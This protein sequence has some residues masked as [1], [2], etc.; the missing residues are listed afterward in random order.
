M[1]L[2]DKLRSGASGTSHRCR[3]AE[4]R[5]RR[6]GGVEGI[7]EE[8]AKEFAAKGYDGARVDEIAQAAGVNKATLYYQ[9]GDKE[10]LYFAVLDQVMGSLDAAI[11]QAVEAAED[12]QEKLRQFVLAFSNQ[13]GLMRY[14]AP[15]ALREVAA[16]GV[17]MPP[18]AMAHMSHVLKTLKEIITLGVDRGDFRPANP[19][20]VHMMIVGS[21]FFYAANG[22]LREKV[23][24]ATPGLREAIPFPSMTEAAEHVA[25]LVIFALKRGDF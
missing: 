15:I 18:A 17:H 22:P 10:A 2:F 9:I 4:R 1:N 12:A 5:C 21:L 23:I 24:A 6:E 16:G 11:G 14:V 19:M 25:D 20:M 7:L 13:D 3:W 8:A